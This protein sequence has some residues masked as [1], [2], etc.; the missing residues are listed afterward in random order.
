MAE[1]AAADMIVANFDD[2]FWV[3]RLPFCGA[4]GAPPAGA[5]RRVAGEAGRHNEPFELLGQRVAVEVVQ[6]RGKPDMVELA[7]AVVEAE[8]QRPDQARV[9]L[10]SEPAD[11]A[12]LLSRRL[13]I[14]PSSAPPLASSQRRASATSRV[15]GESLTACTGPIDRKKTSRAARR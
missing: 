12:K 11:Y 6:R 4:L 9:P 14:T 13:A 8:E 5:S 10:I 7:F 1:S 2:Q 3:H 15:K